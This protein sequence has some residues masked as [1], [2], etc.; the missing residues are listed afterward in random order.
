MIIDKRMK[1]YISS[2]IRWN[3]GV[4]SIHI[5]DIDETFWFDN[6]IALQDFLNK[7]IIERFSHKELRKGYFNYVNE[8]GETLQYNIL[9]IKSGKIL[10]FE[11][12]II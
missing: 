1:K 12:L 11:T 3:E 8:N 6:N 10:N 5:Q 9:E 4:S 2:F 7:Q